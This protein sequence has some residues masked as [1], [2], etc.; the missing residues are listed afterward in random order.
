MKNDKA[1]LAIVCHFLSV[2]QKDFFMLDATQLLGVYK[3][4]QYITWCLRGATIA[5][6]FMAFP[7]F[8]YS[9]QDERVLENL[10]KRVWLWFAGPAALAAVLLRVGRWKRIIKE[11]ESHE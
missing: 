5:L 7:L 6:V 3:N 1:V 8:Y 4:R 11:R 10:A 9:F 2:H